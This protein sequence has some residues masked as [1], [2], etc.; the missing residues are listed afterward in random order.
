MVD[1]NTYQ[2]PGVFVEEEPSTLVA[3]GSASTSAVAIVG[4]SV[5]YRT[6]TEAV[7]LNGTSQVTLSHLG[8]NQATIVVTSASGTPFTGSDYTLASTTGADG[9]SGTVV[10]NA[11]MIARESAG[12]ITDGQTVYVFYQY[13]DAAYLLPQRATDMDD[14]QSFYGPAFDVSNTQVIS[15]LTLAAKFAFDNGAKSLVLLATPG[16]GTTTTTDLAAAYPRL[17]TM[18]DVAFVVPLPIGIVGTDVTPG[19]LGDVG[20]DLK[21]YLETQTSNDLLRIGIIGTDVVGSTNP[22]TLVAQYTSK[23]VMHAYP[24]RL[25]YFIGASNT[26]I[27][28]GGCYLA[29]AY[30]GRFAGLPPQ[31]PLTQKAIRG[32][33]GIP[34]TVASQMTTAQKNV[35]SDAGVAVAQV[36]RA[37][38]LVVRHGTST[39][40]TSTLTREVSLVRAR[41]TL[42]NLLRD[43]LDASGMIGTY[44]DADTTVRLQGVITGILESAKAAE[45]ILDYSGVK[46]RQ[47]P[48]LPSVIDVKFQYIPAYPLNYVVVTFSIDTSTGDST[49]TA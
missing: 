4:P 11:T 15:P 37:N 43:T 16:N 2:P 10:D 13:T 24:Y 45:T 5:G 6:A 1:F 20:A 36:T 27:E 23:R 48:G 47:R 34:A 29:A 46:V 12:A 40:R 19:N 17:N 3:I 31:E 9:V 14:V 32:F 41:D 38:T 39:D 26:T 49:L 18:I 42:V 28:V 30:A 33:S 7:T 25:L 22:A 8:I 35:W 44:I 21:D